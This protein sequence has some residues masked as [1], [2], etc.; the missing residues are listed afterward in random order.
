MARDAWDPQQLPD[1]TGRRYLVTGSNAGLGYFS[2]E[3]LVRAGA[4]VVMTGRNPNR[5]S[6]ARAAL[7]RRV[8]EAEGRVETLILD[9]SN[10]GSVRAAAASAATSGPVHGVLLNAG[11]THPPKQ[12]ETTPD[13][14]ELVFATNALGHFGLAGE[15][16]LPL[17][18][19]GGRLVWLGSLSTT[20]SPYDPVDPQL[21]EGY[22]AWR[23]YVQS[24]VATTSLGFEADR[25]LRAAGVSVS[26]LVAH[27]G[28]S[29][30]GRTPGIQG[31]N[32]PSRLKR[33]ADNLQGPM[34]QSKEHGAWPLVR[35]L[36]D[37]DA[38]G[39]QF[40]GPQR[41]TRG[42]PQ[43][44]R[45]SKITRDPEIAARLWEFCERT[46]RVQWP[47]EKAAKVRRR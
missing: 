8:D 22:T 44:A 33:F 32:Q 18:K 43:V 24:K 1:L 21:V 15:L 10:L 29:I 6:A 16:L 31:V 30:G 47:F 3:Q 46:A 26:S 23:A 25:R 34:T 35:A 19:T 38:E 4:R 17:A 11:I 13:G 12:R 14:I 27:P 2:C 28:Y 5:L 9:T 37:P 42:A 41:L 7:H 45:P 40:Y 20:I 39:G 36:I